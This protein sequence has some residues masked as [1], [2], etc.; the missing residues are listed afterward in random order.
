MSTGDVAAVV[1]AVLGVTDRAA[2]LAAVGDGGLLHADGLRRLLDAAAELVQTDP[3]SAAV[4]AG[5]GEDGAATIGSDDLTADAAYLRARLAAVGGDPLAALRLLDR[6]RQAYRDAGR[7]R[8]AAR[9]VLGRMEVLYELGRHDEAVA[10]GR[11]LL[12]TVVGDTDGD[13]LLRAKV[14]QNLGV[15]AAFAGRLEEASD[16]YAAAEQDYRRAGAD[17]ATAM[18]ALN[19]GEVLLDLGR[20]HDAMAAFREAE[21]GA[22][23]QG[24][25]LLAAQAVTSQA[26]VHLL[27]GRFADVLPV[28][29]RT[30]AAFAALDARGD[31]DLLLYRTGEAYLALGLVEE[32]AHTFREA[33]R[34][35]RRAGRQHLLAAALTGLGAALQSTGHPAEA[36]EALAEAGQ[37]AEVVGD[38]PRRAA[39]LL[40][41]ASLEQRSGRPGQALETARLAAAVLEA[42]PWVLGQVYAQLRVADLTG[43]PRSTE[44]ALDEAERRL[45]GLDLPPLRFRILARRGALR[46]R[47]GR[48]TEAE[49]LLR[50]AIELVERQRAALPGD[51][52]RSSFLRDRTAP[53]AELLGLLL[54]RGDATALEQAFDLA[55]RARSR[56]L[57]DLLDGLVRTRRDT[58]APAGE[59]DDDALRA[60]SEDLAAVYN[61]LLGQG[62]EQDRG[63]STQ[64]LRAL[65]SRA[66][67]LEDRIAVLQLRRQELPGPQTAGEPRRLR[68]VQAVLDDGEAVLAYQLLAD[69]IVAFLVDA[70]G[71]DVVR[72]V[73]RVTAVRSALGRLDVQWRR[74]R[75]GSAFRARHGVRLQRAAERVLA[76]L[77][78]ELLAALA[79]HPR[80]VGVRALRVVPDGLL[81]GVPFHALPLRGAPLADRYEVS[82]APNATL[83]AL[84]APHPAGDTVRTLVLG[85]GGPDVPHVTAEARAV[86]GALPGSTLLLDRAATRDALV[87]GVPGSRI[88]HIACHG[89]FRPRAP[90]FSSLRLGDGWLTAADA[91]HL[92]LAGALVV[93][94]ACESGRGRAQDGGDEVL[95]LARAFLGAGAAAVVVSLWLVQ[96]DV[97]ADLMARW[98]RHLGAGASPACALRR[99][100]GE[101]RET[102]PHPHHW[103][104][105]VLIGHPDTASLRPGA[106]T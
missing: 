27:L 102:H 61:G 24:H 85:V 14:R 1:T 57:I 78:A 100:Q 26:R 74:F 73:G 35:F 7:A 87:H 94:S 69:E 42:G 44:L 91:L 55:E 53:Y 93:L 2:R 67:D 10:E 15:F 95:G 72:R 13:A 41:Q 8:D 59:G 89:L 11:A 77:S 29:R 9:T 5:T 19:R 64:Q 33:A 101:L 99:A 79:A 92:D 66:A 49:P 90:M 22:A 4:L 38:L 17:G 82:V 86:A 6:S 98:Y 106:P 50:E 32:A 97:T 68:A 80:L 81:H 25:S 58:V 40:E 37:L 28:L 34:S 51:A 20:G 76:D 48:P 31:A 104:P 18:L 30:R 21:R 71:V 75:V 96:D 62:P 56:A 12:D 103:A 43:E 36:H 88:V 52:L 60:L 70:E 3:T 23:Q 65:E 84:P 16:L 83:L 45:R 46:R 63:A 54:D 39:V 47:T 105:F